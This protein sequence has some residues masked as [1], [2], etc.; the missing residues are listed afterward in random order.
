MDV[1]SEVVI[2]NGAIVPRIISK[3][4]RW[5]TNTLHI[6]TAKPTPLHLHGIDN[7]L[8]M[9]APSSGLKFV[10]RA[11]TLHLSSVLFNNHHLIV[12]PFPHS[13]CRPFQREL[14]GFTNF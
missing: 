3:A 2:S 5:R 6:T 12:L 11:G 7:S 4:Q 14:Q 8:M 13:C 9:R 10:S 1:V